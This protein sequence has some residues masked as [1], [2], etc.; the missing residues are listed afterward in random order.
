M[1]LFI[2]LFI[3]SSSQICVTSFIYLTTSIPLS[4]FQYIHIPGYSSIHP[5][6]YPSLFQFISIYLPIHLLIYPPPICPSCYPPIFQSIHPSTHHP[7]D[8]AVYP[9]IQKRASDPSQ[10]PPIHHC[11][12]S[13]SSDERLCLADREEHH[14]PHLAP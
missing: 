13:C 2:Y 11:F 5:L 8:I 10:P 6:S 7:I 4:T 14:Y 12:L 9:S 1:C 3:H